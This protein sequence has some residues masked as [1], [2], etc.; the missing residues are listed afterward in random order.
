[1]RRELVFS[2][3]GLREV[4]RRAGEEYGSSVVVLMESA[5]RAVAE[6]VLLHRKGKG[7]VMV[8]CGGGE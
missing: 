2:R 6:R 7:R 1:M 4:D 8:V 3:A 5:G